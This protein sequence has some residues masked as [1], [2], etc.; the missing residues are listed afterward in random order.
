MKAMDE[1]SRLLRSWPQAT[2]T[3][4]HHPFDPKGIPRIMNKLSQL[5][6]SWPQ[7]VG[8]SRSPH[9]DSNH[10]EVR[11]RAP[12]TVAE[13][14]FSGDRPPVKKPADTPSVGTNT[15]DPKDFSGTVELTPPPPVHVP[16]QNESWPSDDFSN[17]LDFT[18]EEEPEIFFG[19]SSGEPVS[20]TFVPFPRSQTPSLVG[21]ETDWEIDLSPSQIA[22]PVAMLDTDFEDLYNEE[23][24]ATI[25][26]LDDEELD[27]IYAGVWKST[28]GSG[29]MKQMRTRWR[30]G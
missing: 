4:Q 1:L 12:E 14:A 30:I 3:P 13:V 28:G 6:G 27:A 23:P 17:S 24:D 8:K 29:S 10:P 21:D 26:D 7:A 15:L 5:L 9:F 25:E 11:D 18:P 2:E 19:R 16:L 20:G 22:N